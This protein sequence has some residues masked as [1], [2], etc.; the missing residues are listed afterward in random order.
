M[1]IRAIPKP[2]SRSRRF[3]CLRRGR[4]S[5]PVLAAHRRFLVAEQCIGSAAFNFGING[6]IAWGLFR[7]LE[8]VPL[9]GRESIAGDT[10]GTCF[11]LP[12]FT[13][14]IVTRLARGRI[15]AGKLP[16]L[17]HSRQSYPALARLPD[18]TLPRSLVFGLVCVVLFAPAALLALSALDVRSL[19]FWPFVS[20]KATFAAALAALVTPMIALAALA[21]GSAD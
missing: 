17:G 8:V 20:L 4:Y 10:F 12:F 18:G 1:E 9:W 16:V 5:A 6:L 3:I 2:E 14:L 13:G 11:F 7:H 15:Q 21:D 19:P